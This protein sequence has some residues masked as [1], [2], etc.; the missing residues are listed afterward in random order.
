MKIDSQNM[1][2]QQ[3][4]VKSSSAM[5]SKSHESSF[6]LKVYPN[7][8]KLQE[9]RNFCRINKLFLDFTQEYSTFCIEFVVDG[10]G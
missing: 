3:V 10:K 9:T 6:N 8:L 2:D 1:H 5:D 4:T 7:R